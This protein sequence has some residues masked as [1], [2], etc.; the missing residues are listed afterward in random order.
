MH[1]K[2]T[3]GSLQL[4]EGHKAEF[5]C[6]IDIPDIRLDHF[7]TWVKNGQELAG[8]KHVL[9][10]DLQTIGDGFMTVLSTVSY[11]QTQVRWY[12]SG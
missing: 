10:K 12:L 4:S 11:V 1:F 3:V 2:P 6:S 9:T 5:N 8:T 7:V